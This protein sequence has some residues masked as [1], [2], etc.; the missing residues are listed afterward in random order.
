MRDYMGSA[1]RV[2]MLI[3]GAVWAVGCSGPVGM[4]SD[5]DLVIRGGRLLDMTSDEPD[6]RPIKG[7]VVSD[8]RVARIIAAD[9]NEELPDAAEVI[10]AGTNT[11]MPGLIDSIFTF[12]PECSNLRFTTESPQSWI[13]HPAGPNAGM[14]PMGLSSGMPNWPMDRMPMGPPCTTQELSWMGPMDLRLWKS[15]V[16][17]HWRKSPKK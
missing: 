6:V 4:E 9:S 12:D 11:V 2:L 10:E 1:T 5:A 16:C 15:T 8:G 17:S 7:L 3:L 14:I 13:P